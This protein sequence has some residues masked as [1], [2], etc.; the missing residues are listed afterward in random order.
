MVFE[1]FLALVMGG[2]RCQLYIV[3]ENEHKTS[4][5]LAGKTAQIIVQVARKPTRYNGM[6]GPQAILFLELAL[7][8]S[9]LHRDS[10]FG[11]DIHSE[12]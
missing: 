8:K 4:G 7:R 2:V 5:K 3:G 10:A 9:V 6:S 11:M 1:P 12:V